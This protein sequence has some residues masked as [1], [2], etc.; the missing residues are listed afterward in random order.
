MDYKMLFD[1][2]GKVCIVTGGSGYLGSACVSALKDFGATVINADI[3]ERKGDADAFIPTDI[4]KTDSFRFLFNQVVEH[5]GKID[6]LVNCAA[7]FKGHGKESQI[8]SMSDE[9]W[10]IGI[11]GVLSSTFRATREVI[12]FMKNLGGSIINFCSM[13]GLVSPDLRIYGKDNPQKNPPN[14]GAA[15]AAIAQ[16][17]RYSASA[18]AE[19]GIRV[20]SVTP[21]PFP[22]P[23][24]S[25]N[26]EFN[27]ALAS[28]TM[29]NRFGKNFEIAGAVLLLASNASS[30]MTGSN[31]VVDGGWTAW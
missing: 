12:P 14:Y 4:S 25:Q 31:I 26:T 28:K 23:S 5:F 9:I 15:K 11:D 10:Q 2:T 7:Y 3:I 18:L 30:F 1:L 29:L 17:T 21:G 22:S 6:V 24:N 8:E 16:F 27:K 19:Y 20:N 13:Y